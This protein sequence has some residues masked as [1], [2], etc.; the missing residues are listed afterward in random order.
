MPGLIQR[1]NAVAE[2]SALISTNASSP[3][4][5]QPRGKDDLSSPSKPRPSR[6]VLREE[7]IEWYEALAPPLED[8]QAVIRRMQADPDLT[9][10]SVFAHLCPAVVLCALFAVALVAA[11]EDS[12]VHRML[13]SPSLDGCCAAIARFAAVA[14]CSVAFG[15]VVLKCAIYGVAE[16]C[17]LVV[18]ME[19]KEQMRAREE[20]GVPTSGLVLGGMML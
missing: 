2:Y 4:R 20:R 8:L 11:R 19:T 14:V 13:D 6:A 3:P 17:A 7:A 15:V 5:R 12:Y 9:Q 16:T 18:G 10:D 1:Y